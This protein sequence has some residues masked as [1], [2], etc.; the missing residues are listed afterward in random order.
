MLNDKI[1]DY[2]V[3]I[4][5]K[6]LVRTCYNVEEAARNI[7]TNSKR[8]YRTL[9]AAGIDIN[10]LKQH[11]TRALADDIK[12]S[13]FSVKMAKEYTFKDIKHLENVAI[14]LMCLNAPE[15]ALVNIKPQ[16]IENRI[17]RALDDQIV[18]D[19][20]NGVHTNPDLGELQW[21]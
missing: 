20:I 5:I 13:V 11:G 12:T 6:E 15:T 3:S 7:G 10:K 1:R 21:H 16:L 14:A 2:T 8:I 19:V 18:Q 17:T 9:E 4:M